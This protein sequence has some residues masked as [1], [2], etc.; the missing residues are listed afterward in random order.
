MNILIIE[1]DPRLRKSYM[2]GLGDNQ[3]SCAESAQEGIDLLST[4]D[5]GHYSLI[6][7]DYNLVK[8]TG[9]EVFY[10]L[11]ENQPASMKQFI[12]VCGAM[13]DINGLSCHSLWKGGM[14]TM[15][16]LKRM[17]ATGDPY[18]EDGDA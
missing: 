15:D 4:T 8:S 9:R 12:F 16:G 5:P 7:C 18:D 11:E 17:L 1:D 3:F 14:D 6:I 13:S 10:W 2:R